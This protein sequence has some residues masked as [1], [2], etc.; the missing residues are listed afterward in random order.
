MAEQ[1]AST[2]LEALAP[3]GAS[4]HTPYWHPFAN[5]AKVRGHELVLTEGRGCEVTDSSGRVYLDAT[6]GLWYCNVGY[7]RE[8]IVDAVARQLRAL[9]SYSTFGPY[10]TEPT[11][12]LAQRI[13]DFSPLPD[14]AVFLTS[15]GS[16]A[17]ETA[18]KLVRAYWTALGEPGKR[19]LVGRPRAYHGM[20]AYGTSLAGIPAN[21]ATFEDMVP[22]V[23]H[24]AEDSLAAVAETF[25][26]IGPENIGAFIG[27]PVIGAGGVFPPPDGFWAG[28]EEICRRHDVL[29]IADEVI[30]GFGRLGRRFGCERY[31]FTP[32]MITFAKGVTSGYMPLGGVIVSE[33]LK[34]PFW[35][36]E[37]RWFRHGYTYSGHAA[38]CAA[39]LANLDIL[40]SEDLVGG[41]AGLEPVLEGAAGELVE[42]PLVGNVRVAGLLCA[43]E[44][45]AAAVAADATLAER[46]VLGCREEGM[47]TRA[48]GLAAVQISPAF[49]IEP[50][51]IERLFAALR[52]S[53]DAADGH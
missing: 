47:L 30:C 35:E 11:L 27:E 21:R 26:R 10:T 41:V 6:A 1:T 22:D 18:A 5:M 38:A 36:G 3:E 45:D 51:Q 44:F 34:A 52:S 37:G 48:L 9:P 15:G 25:A 24:I 2:P 17:V 28:V 8:E 4:N 20:H 16:D 7:G 43:V 23:A 42:H 50:A 12:E 53:L 31:G 40:E 19:V 13:A 32:D 49:V 14:P 29:L 46:V 39:A 33:R